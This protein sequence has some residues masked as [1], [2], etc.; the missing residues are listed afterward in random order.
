M[1]KHEKPK[2]NEVLLLPDCH[3]GPLISQLAYL[4]HRVETEVV[5]PC[6][7]Q[8]GN[9]RWERLAWVF[10]TWDSCDPILEFLVQV[11]GPPLTVQLP[12][13]I[14][15]G[16][17]WV[18]PLPSIRKAQTE[19]LT[20]GFI[21]PQPWLLYTFGAWTSGWEII[22]PSMYL[23]TYLPTNLS[24]YSFKEIKYTKLF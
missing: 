6:R 24:T 21:L 13:N 9:L 17:Q 22:Y 4:S 5:C 11:P 23:P 1:M 10:G 18:I 15:P 16:R 19:F 2:L 14:H 8:H 20:H 12:A 3:P 7:W